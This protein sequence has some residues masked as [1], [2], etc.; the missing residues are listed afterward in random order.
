M[1]WLGALGIPSTPYSSPRYALQVGKLWSTIMFFI[2]IFAR[3]LQNMAQ[4]VWKSIYNPR[5][6]WALHGFLY[7]SFAPLCLKILISPLGKCI[8]H[9]VNITIWPN[10]LIERARADEN[11][12]RVRSTAKCKQCANCM[13]RHYYFLLGVIFRLFQSFFLY[14]SWKKF[15]AFLI[16]LQTWCVLPVFHTNH[17]KTT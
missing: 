12:Q 2:P 7:T 3:M 6:S 9:W 4:I 13:C 1:R 10:A 8:K 16:T 11:I 15:L 5:A 14:V 17:T